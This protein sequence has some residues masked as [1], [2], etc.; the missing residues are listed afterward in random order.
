MKGRPR[1][2][3][4]PQRD[5]FTFVEIL[6]AMLFLGILIPVVI[7]ALLISNR[8]AVVAERSTV[9]A[10]LG[11]NQLNELMLGDAWTSSAKSGDFGQEW[12]GYRWE[13]E[14]A[15]WNSGAMTELTLDVFFNVQGQDHEVRLS[16]LVNESLSLAATQ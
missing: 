12:P 9:A 14:S 4:S 10:Q 11:E 16:T 8:A 1:H 2:A 3:R 6:A 5:G 13:L 15:D 7:S